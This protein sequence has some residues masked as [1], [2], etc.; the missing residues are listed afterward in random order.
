MQG[1]GLTVILRARGTIKGAPPPSAWIAEIRTSSRNHLTSRKIG[2]G[3]TLAEV[4]KAY[5]G[6]RRMSFGATTSWWMLDGPGQR[7]TGFELSAI[8]KGNPVRLITL[9]CS[10]GTAYPFDR[11]K[12]C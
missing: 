1:K 8:A 12:H 4:K 3:S 10:A 11:T 2:V 6:G 9:G 7:R 5:P